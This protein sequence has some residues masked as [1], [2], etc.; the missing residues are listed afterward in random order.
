MVNIFTNLP[1]W[2]S[3]VKISLLMQDNLRVVVEAQK[4]AELAIMYVDTYRYPLACIAAACVVHARQEFDRQSWTEELESCVGFTWSEILPAVRHIRRVRGVK[5][6]LVAVETKYR[7]AYVHMCRYRRSQLLYV[8]PRPVHHQ[9]C[10]VVVD[11]RDSDGKHQL[12]RDDGNK[13]TARWID[14]R[15]IAFTIESLAVTSYYLPKPGDHVI[16]YD[17]ID[18]TVDPLNAI[19]RKVNHQKEMDIWSV[20]VE[21]ASMV[22]SGVVEK[23][24]KLERLRYFKWKIP[25]A[26]GRTS[27]NVVSKIA[28]WT[29]ISERTDVEREH[30]LRTYW[31]DLELPRHLLCPIANSLMVDPVIAEDGY[32]YERVT[33][34][35]WISKSLVSPMTGNLLSKNELRS[36]IVI[37]NQVKRVFSSNE[38]VDTASTTTRKQRLRRSIRRSSRK[39]KNEG[40]EERKA[41]DVRQKLLEECF[42]NDES[43][44]PHAFLCPLTSQL[45]V[46]PVVADNGI[47]YEKSALLRISQT[48]S[49]DKKLWPNRLLMSQIRNYRSNLVN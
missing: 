17:R 49:D 1:H 5:S 47:S 9:I 48:K 18:E 19:V 6:S 40:D 43:K 16:V 14:L 42:E 3:D 38:S 37:R 24:V 21:Y 45:L 2:M 39:R 10:D 25:N 27:S 41:R 28:R 4:N 12:L 23:D 20:D 30:L 13:A 11:Y 8:I 46:D 7:D 26:S 31:K 34:S 32:T 35:R 22:V 44:V 36:N 29:Q 15:E 33:I